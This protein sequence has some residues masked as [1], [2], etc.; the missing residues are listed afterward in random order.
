MKA[1]NTKTEN[2]LDNKRDNILRSVYFEK[3]EYIPMIS[4]IN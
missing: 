1:E 3:P 4:H 2:I